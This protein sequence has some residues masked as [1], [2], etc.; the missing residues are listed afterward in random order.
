M[1]LRDQ[2]TLATAAAVAVS[3]VLA[4]VAVFLVVR[5]HLRDQ[6]DRSLQ[7]ERIAV[8]IESAPAVAGVPVAAGDF[9]LRVP[10]PDPGELAPYVQLIADD[11]G[12]FVGI[13]GHDAIPP[14]Q[15]AL[16][17]ARSGQA[18]LL[19]DVQH[20]GDHLRMLT[21]GIEPGLAVQVA[22]SLR[23]VDATLRWLGIFLA[24]LSVA[25]IAFA[26]VLGRT[27]ARAALVPVSNLTT[28]VEDISATSDLSRRIDVRGRDELGRLASSFNRMLEALAASS[29]A[30][31]RLVADASH[32]LRTPLTSIRTNTELLMRA[33]FVDPDERALVGGAIINEVD[34][35][36][37][38]VG[39]VVELARGIEPDVIDDAVALDEV[40]SDVVARA[41]RRRPDIKI[42]ASISATTVDGDRSRLERAVSNLVDNAIKWSPSGSTVVVTLRDREL[43]VSDRGPGIADTDMPRVFDRFYRA[44][45]ARSQPGSGLGLAIVRQVVTD[46]GGQVTAENRPDGGAVFRVRFAAAR[47]PEAPS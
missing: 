42:E 46:H 23:E 9:V 25:G 24:I 20:R 2:F 21:E 26:A 17:V 8:G 40:V 38:L 10:S 19:E 27:V 33:D 29:A 37:D 47:I 39:D 45:A 32:E 43:S 7:A 12:V 18:S 35:L 16:R 22:R 4:A 6:V 31:K 36:S 44:A 34:E 30:Q 13:E 11:G 5:T 3:I 14:S 28:A 41:N 15:E 1:K